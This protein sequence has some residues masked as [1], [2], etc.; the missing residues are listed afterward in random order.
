MLITKSEIVNKLTPAYVG[1]L[2]KAGVE[3]HNEVVVEGLINS[4][5]NEFA[6]FIK[7]LEIEDDQ[8]VTMDFSDSMTVS[9]SDK[10][11]VS[12]QYRYYGLKEK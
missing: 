1:V 8:L 2:S 10:I 7:D 4:L 12:G 3:I 5:L 11:G 9:I 6:N